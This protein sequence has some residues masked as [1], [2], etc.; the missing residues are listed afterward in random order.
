MHPIEEKLPHLPAQPGVY[1][2][3]GKQGTV[4][5]VGKA[6]NLKARLRA[7]VG[8]SAAGW[9][10]VRFL[11]PKVRALDYIVTQTE[12]EALLLENT[13]IKKHR[14]QYNIHLKDDKTYLHIMLDRNH[15]FPRF[16]PVRRPNSKADCLVFGPY[17]SSSAMRDTLHQIHKIYPLRTCK[18]REFLVRKRPCLQYQMGRCGGACAG[19]ISSEEYRHMV[20]QAILILR[21]RSRE[22]VRLLEEEMHAAAEA[23]HFEEAALVRDRLK[24][25]QLTMEQQRVVDTRQVDL[26]VIGHLQQEGFLEIVLLMIRSGSLMECRGFPF[27]DVVIPLPE[28][29]PSF[30][31]QY[32]S[33]SSQVLPGEILLPVELEDREALEDALNDLGKGVCSIKTPKKG[34][35]KRLVELAH[36]NAQSLLAEHVR[37]DEKRID[38]LQELQQKLS[39]AKPPARIECF[40]ISNIQGELAVGS[41][42]AFRDGRPF[43][44][45]YRRFKI[46][47]LQGVD[48]Y[49]MMYEVL[50]RRFKKRENRHEWPDL[51]LIDGGKGH[52]GVALRALKDLGIQDLQV[53]AIAKAPKPERDKPGREESPEK[54][55]DRIFLPGRTNPVNFSAPFHGLLFLQQVR[56]EAHRFAVA[57]HRKLRSRA[58]Q[59]SELDDIPG[60]GPKRKKALLQALGDIE[61][62]RKASAAEL[63][64]IAGMNEKAA[65]AVYSHFH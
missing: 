29:L 17:S 62:I 52:L 57:Y 33:Q 8:A 18:D 1:I 5:Y 38:L 4:L 35:K 55:M 54:G 21:G 20:E 51:L 64:R 65:L 19:N 23:M 22:L 61:S 13:L 49:G 2:M 10:K 12:K 45:G 58:M 40:D 36:K 25:T 39:L 50:C 24:A 30:L 26:D 32:Y 44:Q 60:I 47:L 14:P 16:V 53:A 37:E 3:K 41:C 9:V 34:E 48:D 42:V 43:R 31:L 28:L 7:Y 46:R 56:D 59:G 6:K 11:V 27:S 15:P 63:S